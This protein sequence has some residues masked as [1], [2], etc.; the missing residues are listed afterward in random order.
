MSAATDLVRSY[1][2][3]EH[4]DY[5]WTD[6]QINASPSRRVM[7][8]M[9]DRA[10]ANGAQPPDTL[11]EWTDDALAK[12]MQAYERAALADYHAG[13]EDSIRSHIPITA[14]RFNGY[15]GKALA[16]VLGAV[17]DN[18]GAPTCPDLSEPLDA[19]ERALAAIRGQRPGG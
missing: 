4:P 9:I 6:D 5:V 1:V 8:R 18:S 12:A 15:V 7:V 16:G 2:Q 14:S 3:A 17:E 11:P 19:I 13:R 10:L